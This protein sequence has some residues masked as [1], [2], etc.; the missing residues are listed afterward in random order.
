MF[1]AAGVQTQ[2]VADRAEAALDALIAAIRPS[3]RVADAR[4]R[5]I[6][7]LRPFKLHP[8]LCGRWDTASVC[9]CTKGLSLTIAVASFW[10]RMVSTPY[11]LDSLTHRP[12]TP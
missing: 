1:V 3:V 2:H 10:S 11:R 4:Q 5:A 12:A 6:E 8:V 9:H 7:A